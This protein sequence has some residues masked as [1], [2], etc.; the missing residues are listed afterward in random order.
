[1]SKRSKAAA[2]ED[3]LPR[4]LAA[5]AK[6]AAKADGHAALPATTC[7]GDDCTGRGPK[8]RVHP[9]FPCACGMWYG[10]ERGRRIHLSRVKSD[11]AEWAKAEAEEREAQAALPRLEALAKA[12][13]LTVVLAHQAGRFDLADS[14]GRMISG[15]WCAAATESVIQ[16]HGSPSRS[17][18]GARWTS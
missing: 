15:G 5:L 14:T 1:M 11:A 6:A 17:A 4:R 16:E 2:K 7:R 12:R 13:G 10:S 3:A 8:H 9:K 18:R